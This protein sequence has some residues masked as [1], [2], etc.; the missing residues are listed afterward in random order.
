MDNIK[1]TNEVRVSP[2]MRIGNLTAMVR[3]AMYDMDD[4]LKHLEAGQNDKWMIERHRRWLTALQKEMN[5]LET[6]E[7]DYGYVSQRNWR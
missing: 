2:Y 7:L 6:Q 1:E 3:G 5:E 4:L